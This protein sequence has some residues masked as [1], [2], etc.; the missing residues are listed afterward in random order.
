VII[1]DLDLVRSIFSPDKAHAILVVDTNCVLP[2][3]VIGQS[4]KPIARRAAKVFQNGCGVYGFQLSTSHP[5]D[6]RW[7]AFR[8]VAIEYG[9]CGGVPERPDHRH[10][11]IN[12]ECIIG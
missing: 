9:F 3:T 1:D 8:Q 4:M 6:A 2:N 12:F 10:L 5:E 11:S 7:K